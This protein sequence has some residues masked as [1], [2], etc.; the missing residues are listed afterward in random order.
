MFDARCK[1]LLVVFLLTAVPARAQLSANPWVD[2][3]SE[4]NIASVYQKNK[5][6]NRPE[7]YFGDNTVLEERPV[8]ANIPKESDK[9]DSGLTDKMK[10]LFSKKKSEEA[11]P[12][13]TQ[14]LKRRVIH[15]G[16]KIS[17]QKQAVSGG[18]SGIP[19]LGFDFS[20]ENFTKIIRR[21]QNSFNANFKALSKQ[22]K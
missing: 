4:E 19:D 11:N 13:P 1:V 9:E 17:N 22:F 8:Y 18:E 14:N 5:N 2:P 6:T 20:G 21:I 10:N 3:N 15:G 7:A 12:T 16:K